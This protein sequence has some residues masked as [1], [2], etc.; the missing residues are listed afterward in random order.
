M[1]QQQVYDFCQLKLFSIKISIY[2]ISFAL[3]YFSK[4]SI[5]CDSKILEEIQSNIDIFEK[6]DDQPITTLDFNELYKITMD[7]LGKIIKNMNS[8]SDDKYA[9]FNIDDIEFYEEAFNDEIQ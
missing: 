1:T 3:K 6:K 9:Q 2:Q 8:K 4:T 5:K 7:P